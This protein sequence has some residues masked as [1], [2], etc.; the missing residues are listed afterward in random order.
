M[1]AVC[2]VY[3]IGEFQ[4]RLHLLLLTLYS[5][6]QHYAWDTLSRHPQGALSEVC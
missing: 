2:A 1:Q 3:L 4:V 5:E 6:P